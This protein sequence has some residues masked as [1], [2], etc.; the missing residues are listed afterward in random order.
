M[1]DKEHL[2]FSPIGVFDS[3]YGGLT[4]FRSIV[5]LLPQYDYI[6]LGDNART[7]YG[8]R[9]NETIYN[10]TWEC[11]QWLRS[12]GCPLI[13]VA[14]NTASANALRTIQQQH[15]QPSQTDDRILGVIRPTAEVVGTYSKTG[16]VGVLGTRATVQSN[17]YPIEIAHYAPEVTVHQL[18]CPMWVPLIE[19]N[20][21]LSAG[22]EYFIQKKV[23]ELTAMN[24]DIDT[25]LLACTHYPLIYDQIKRHLKDGVT[26]LS[27]GDIV[28]RSLKQYLQRHKEMDVRLTRGGTTL[29]YTTDNTEDFERHAAI[30]FGEH[31]KAHYTDLKPEEVV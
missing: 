19:N 20:E 1:P 22:A 2:Q 3:G 4:V 30:F 29:F 13:I 7:P 14:C 27:Q 11:M 23:N 5:D 31:V 10:Y 18:A 25:I 15:M 12:A 17:S 21:H 24:A 16:D 9:S 28:A 8:N 26:L 6:Y